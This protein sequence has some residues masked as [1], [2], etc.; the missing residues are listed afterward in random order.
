[1]A[2]LEFVFRASGSPRNGYPSI[3]ASGANAC[4]LHYTENT[5]RM[6]DGDLLLIDAGCEWGYYSADITRTFPVNGRFTAAQRAVYEIV[7]RAQLAGIAAARPGNRYEA[8]HEAAR[9]VL[10]EGLVALGALPRGIGIRIEDDVLMTDTGCEV[11]TAGTPK[12]IDEVERACAEPP[13][14]PRP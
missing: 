1:Q 10:T 11:L 14:L 7:L 6:E 9:R 2:A 8:I 13:R 5:R 4:I 12:T 3:V